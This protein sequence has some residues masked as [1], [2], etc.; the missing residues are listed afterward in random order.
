MESVKYCHKC[1]L[2]CE[3]E[4][5]F[6]FRCGASLEEYREQ[7]SAVMATA[8]NARPS[9]EEASETSPSEPQIFPPT[10]EGAAVETGPGAAEP[11]AAEPTYTPSVS[12]PGVT[13]PASPEVTGP[14]MPPPSLFVPARKP[15]RATAM[16]SPLSILGSLAQF[17]GGVVILLSVF[18][19]YSSGPGRS[20]TGWEWFRIGNM[21]VSGGGDIGTPFF[22]H[23]EGYPVFTGLTFLVIGG[24]L[25][26]TGFFNLVLG[27]R[28][29]ATVGL[30]LSLIALAVSLVNLTSFLRQPG[31]GLGV[32]II[33]VLLFSLIGVAGSAM[34]IAS[35]GQAPKLPSS[36]AATPA[37]ATQGTADWR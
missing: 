23:L 33:L 22:V 18:L 27:N 10:H 2:A 19:A 15:F 14:S 16:R 1:G 5:R 28:K 3:P 26:I 29:T 6:C 37:A 11:T 7:E 35:R 8:D 36:S 20:L 24:M 17:L 32:G 9:L 25:A 31:A 4:D 12:I 34:N 21:A 13:P 30:A